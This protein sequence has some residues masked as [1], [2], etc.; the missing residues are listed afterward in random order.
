MGPDDSV[1]QAGAHDVELARALVPVLLERIEST[2]AR[3][4]RIEMRLIE[5]REDDGADAELARE[6]HEAEA[7]GWL[8]GWISGG[9]GAELLLERHEPRALELALDLVR[10]ALER[11]GCRLVVQA[12]PRITKAGGWRLAWGVA[13]LAWRAGSGDGSGSVELEIACEQGRA[14]IAA[15]GDPA[16]AV[17]ARAGQLERELAGSQFLCGPVGWSWCFPGEWLEVPV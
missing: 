3:I 8:L 4:A 17:R 14:R 10:C 5:R 6:A 16:A 12:V 1:A 15:A 7:L 9:L 13:G 2:T 11:Q